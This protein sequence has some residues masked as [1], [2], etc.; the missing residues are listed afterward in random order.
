MA[1]CRLG[2]FLIGKLFQA[3]PQI[4]VMEMDEKISQYRQYLL[5]W[6]FSLDVLT[7]FRANSSLVRLNY[8]DLFQTFFV[9]K[10]VIL[11]QIIPLSNIQSSIATFGNSS[12]SCKKFKPGHAVTAW[13]LAKSLGYLL[14]FL[15]AAQR[16]GHGLLF[17]GLVVLGKT[18]VL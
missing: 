1:D 18:I 8:F 2:Q 4:I 15:P 7:A 12:P 10:K 9:N 16:L 6:L 17:V 14:I 5:S 11:Q 13:H 3:N